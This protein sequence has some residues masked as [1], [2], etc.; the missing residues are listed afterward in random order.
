[1]CVPMPMS[2]Y[3]HVSFPYKLAVPET[4]LGFHQAIERCHTL[5]IPFVCKLVI[6]EYTACS[7]AAFNMQKYWY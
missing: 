3:F 4:T 2:W 1:M 7:D 5:T 6:L